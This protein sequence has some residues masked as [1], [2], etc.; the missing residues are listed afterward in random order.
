MK[1]ALIA[2]LALL[3][4]GGGGGAAY[5]FLVMKKEPI[6]PEKNKAPVA[7]TAIK[8]ESKLDPVMTLKPEAEQEP[9]DFYVADRKLKV[10]NEPKKDGLITDYLYKGKKVTVLETKGNWVR[11]SDYIVLREG[12]PQ[13]AKWVSMSGLSRNEVVITEKENKEILD[14]YLVKSDD[15]KAH[16]EMFRNTVAKLIS[17]GDCAPSDFDELGGWVKSL[18]YRNR[19]VYFIYCDGLSLEN[20]I[21]LDVNTGKTFTE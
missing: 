16:R 20:K 19:D 3:I 12:E 4:L 1:K 2:L 17:E 14:S 6:S 10:L 13:T 7:E 11:I 18:K 15:L 8:S 5:Y 21:Y 9:K